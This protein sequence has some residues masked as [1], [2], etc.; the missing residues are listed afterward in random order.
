MLLAG[1][2]RESIDRRCELAERAGE[3]AESCPDIAEGL[4][5]RLSKDAIPLVREAAGH[6]LARLLASSDGWTRTCI[7]SEWASSES[8]ADRAT[9]ARALRNRTPVLGAL[10]V[11]ETLSH[12]AYSEVRRAVCEAVSCRLED[13]PRRCTKIL[14]SRAQDNRRSVRLLAI[15]GLQK[16]IEFG[17]WED[18]IDALIACADDADVVCAEH[19][20][21][22][23]ASAHAGMAL[24]GLEQ[25][26][27]HPEDH[28]PEVLRHVI[29]DVTRIGCRPRSHDHALRVLRKLESHPTQWVQNDAH[30]AVEIIR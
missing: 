25:L 10:S 4:L 16:A 1:G 28:D 23:L 29:D 21:D 5:S 14:L 27:A 11:L 26:V 2:L 13:A 18:T 30:R 17:L 20:I 19:A 8:S 6:G 7:V 15:D 3:L 22:A 24:D 12:D 9:V